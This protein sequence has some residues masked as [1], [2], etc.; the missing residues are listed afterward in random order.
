M[1][2]REVHGLRRMISRSRD[3]RHDGERIITTR[4][5]RP[6]SSEHATRPGRTWCSGRDRR[7]RR[8]PAAPRSRCDRPSRGSSRV[9]CAVRGP[10]HLP[11]TS[12]P[13]DFEP[14]VGEDLPLRDR[15]NTHTGRHDRCGRRGTC[16]A[17]RHGPGELRPRRGDT[18]ADA[19]PSRRCG[20]RS[21][22]RRT[23]RPPTRTID[24]RDRP[25]PP[26]RGIKRR[27][28]PARFD[29]VDAARRDAIAPPIR[30]S[31]RP[32]PPRRLPRT[33][34]CSAWPASS[35]G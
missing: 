22:R 35:T 23:V 14:R 5:A 18:R 3:D 2:G 13:D 32:S 21:A 34:G 15:C 6:R 9:I 1:A 31:S 17:S 8:A 11:Y 30:R 25:R 29:V 16:R 28:I 24:R 10:C 7:A 33:G 26:D 27:P 4:I 20:P 12:G 19:R